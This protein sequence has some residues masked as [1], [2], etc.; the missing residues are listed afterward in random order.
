MD[1]TLGNTKMPGFI[2]TSILKIESSPLKQFDFREDPGDGLNTPSR[3]RSYRD[4]QLSP[5][6]FDLSRLVALGYIK[7][8]R[9]ITYIWC[10][11]L[12]I[13]DATF[14]SA[15][16]LAV[17]RSDCIEYSI[18]S[19]PCFQHD[20]QAFCRFLGLRCRCRGFSRASQGT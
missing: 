16:L 14:L 2:A 7:C 12:T 8:F 3:C 13:S 6:S 4:S 19:Q 5:T 10:L 1:A 9:G 15:L 18:L 11:M 17:A 20:Q